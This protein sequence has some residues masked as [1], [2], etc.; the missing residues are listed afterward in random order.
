MTVENIY[1]DFF[2]KFNHLTRLTAQNSLKE[3]FPS[4]SLSAF[5]T[6]L[7]TICWSCVSLRLFPTIIF[8]TWN[9]S[10]FDM[11]P[12]LSIS[13]I[14]KATTSKQKTNNKY[15]EFRAGYSCSIYSVHNTLDRSTCKGSNLKDYILCMTCKK[16][17]P[18]FT[19]S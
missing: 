12:S 17:M 8:R 11:K 10:P 2:V 4:P 1:V 15:V 13:Y 14:L 18:M 3:I 7:S 5:I 16:R 19:V 9:S 6:V